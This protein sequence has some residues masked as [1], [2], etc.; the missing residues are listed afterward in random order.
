MYTLASDE[1]DNHYQ[2]FIKTLELLQE[3]QTGTAALEGLLDRF[4]SQLYHLRIGGDSALDEL[5]ATKN[6][7]EHWL[8]QVMVRTERLTV[9]EDRDGT[10]LPV[11]RNTEPIN[12]RDIESYLELQRISDSLGKGD[13][14][15]Y[16][17]ASPYLMDFMDDY[18]LKRGC[19]ELS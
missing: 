17:K 3:D 4:R 10:L 9:T 1:E 6:E 13:I 15:E 14:L 11:D 7:L 8:R 5:V 2:D 19:S 16:W 12:S 18:E